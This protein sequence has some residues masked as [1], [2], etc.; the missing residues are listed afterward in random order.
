MN[1]VIID[2]SMKLNEIL[3]ECAKECKV[4]PMKSLFGKH[5]SEFFMK[6]SFERH[7]H[8]EFTQEILAKSLEARSSG[9]SG[10]KRKDLLTLFVESK[11][12][13]DPKTVHDA[14]VSFLLASKGT[15]VFG[16][17][18]LVVKLNRYPAV[19]VKICDG[20]REKLP[21]L[22]IGELQIRTME[23]LQKLYYLEA[24]VKESLTLHD[25]AK[26]QDYPVIIPVYASTRTKSAWGNDDAEFNLE[27]WIDSTTGKV[28]P[29]SLFK[30]ITLIGDLH[31]CL[32]MRFAQLQL[33]TTIAVLS[34]AST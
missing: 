2:K 3:A 10:M 1:E 23:D 30:F 18:W 6:I 31:Q 32:G 25:C 24:V 13:I 14:L 15:T 5:S 29:V 8:G 20:I 26:P 7:D 12:I 4:V 16:S 9:W 22:M 17:V 21:G 27:R 19:L 28:K 33:Q 11:T 34:V